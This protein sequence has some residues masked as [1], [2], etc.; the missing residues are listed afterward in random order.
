MS[1][2]SCPVGFFYFVPP[3]VATC[4]DSHMGKGG[5]QYKEKGR[6]KGKAEPGLG[7][8]VEGGR[9]KGV[10]ERRESGILRC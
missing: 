2:V 6:G 1:I 10:G 7:A 5:G 8:A 9:R 3:K 4:A